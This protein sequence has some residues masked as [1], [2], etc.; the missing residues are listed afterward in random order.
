MRART[1]HPG[2]TPDRVRAATGFSLTLEGS[3]PATEP[4]SDA[5]LAY[6]RKADPEGFWTGDTMKAG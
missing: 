1:L 3:L 6:I 4:P 2:V 5:E